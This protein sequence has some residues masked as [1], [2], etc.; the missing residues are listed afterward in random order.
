MKLFNLFIITSLHLFIFTSL[1]VSAKNKVATSPNGNISITY[2]G[3]SITVTDGQNTYIKNALV[4]LEAEQNGKAIQMGKGIDIELKAFDNGVAY[5]FVSKVKGDYIILNEK[6]DYT[7]SEDYT[8]YLP[9]ST[10]PQKPQAMAFQA[11]FDVA[12]ISKQGSLLAFLPLAVDCKTAKLTLLES[13]LNAYPG[14]FVTCEGTTLKTQF[15][16]Y[17]KNM[18]YYSYRHMSYVKDT[19]DYI[20]K[21]NGPRT[22][23]WRIIAIAHDDTEMPTSDL[24]AKLAEPSR[25]TDISWIKYGRVAWDWWNDWG[26]TGVPFKAGI[27]TQTY[28]YYIDFASRYGLEYIIL[29]EGWYDSRTGDI[30]NAIPEVNLP[31]LIAYG[32]Q[33]NVG[34]ILWCVF[35]V[36]DE[37]LTA[38]CEKY[39]KM[40]AVGF[41][42]DF[43]DR[44]DQ[45]A[46]EMT[47]RIAEECAKHHLFLDYHGIYSPAGLNITYPNVINFEAVFGMEEAKWTN[48]TRDNREPQKDMPLYDVTFPF[49]RLQAGPVDFTPGGMRN[50]TKTDYQPV[51]SNPMTM[52]TRLHQMAN[53]VVHNTNL[54]MFADSP[55]AYEREPE[56]TKLLASLP[57][58]T[59]TDMKVLY[60]KIGEYIVV[61]RT[62][63]DGNLYIG[64]QTN[65]NQRDIQVNCADF[66]PEGKA[67]QATIITDGPNAEKNACD[68]SQKSQTLSHSSILP[69]HLASGGGFV[70]IAK[71]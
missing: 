68:W 38:A 48:R 22:F 52:G 42:V 70:I 40:G 6:A 57:A 14:M 11:T 12:P 18:A 44:N 21:C 50:A 61:L 4:A 32:K 41:K 29:D 66:I 10:N 59:Y 62:D 60:G 54:T 25:L 24:V 23:P 7:F 17:P 3:S 8:S 27:N 15:A 56:F 69:I 45:T 19:E 2:D 64:G 51:Y 49:I 16:K 34:I 5:R 53:Y 65:W 35:N 30:M 37:N 33:K 55:T 46:V 31:E 67:Y 36:L 71:K 13:D 63:K 47:Y 9:H 26:L 20:A 1:S 43:M 28:K 39:S 58:S